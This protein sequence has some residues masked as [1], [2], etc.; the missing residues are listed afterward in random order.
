MIPVR[1]A[2]PSTVKKPTSEPSEIVPPH[3]WRTRPNPF[4]EVWSEVCGLLELN[5]G[6]QAKT[7]FG[8]ATDRFGPRAIQTRSVE[9]N[10]HGTDVRAG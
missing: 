8:L 5:P 9:T 7:I 3:D 6:L 4:G 1:A 10:A 2:I